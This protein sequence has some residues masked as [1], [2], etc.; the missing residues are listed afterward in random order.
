MARKPECAKCGEV[1]EP[2]RDNESCCKKCKSEMRS[3]RAAKKRAE[4]GKLPWGSGRSPYCSICGGDI[5]GK[6]HSMCDACRNERAKAA[7]HEKNLDPEV[8][9]QR[10]EER[11]KLYQEDDLYRQKM[12]ARNQAIRAINDGTLVR[13]PCEVC[14]A[15]KVDAHHEDY[16]KSL[17]VRW[18]CRVHH[19]LHHERNKSLIKED[20]LL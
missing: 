2:G 6:E 10:R 16:D 1:K 4:V 17:D 11:R 18:L 14:G 3:A 9:K 19:R 15:K 20:Y 13:Q 5:G 12:V 7:Y 8:A